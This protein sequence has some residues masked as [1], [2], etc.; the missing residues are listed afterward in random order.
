VPIRGG[1]VVDQSK[2]ETAQVQ[3]ACEAAETLEGSRPFL[4]FSVLLFLFAVVFFFL[5]R[6]RRL[7]S[8]DIIKSI[9]IIQHIITQ[10]FIISG[11]TAKVSVLLLYCEPIGVERLSDFGTLPFF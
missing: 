11:L 7:S 8:I 3:E 5:T 9:E 1:G 4:D 10:I 6:I 2:R